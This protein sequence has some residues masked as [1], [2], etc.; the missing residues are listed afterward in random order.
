MKNSILL[1]L[2][3]LITGCG[4]S[5]PNSPE[6]QIRSVLTSIEEGV[7]NRSLSQVT[8]LIDDDYRDHKGQTKK[9]IKRYI[10]LQILRNQNIS[11]L[12]RVSSI[13]IEGTSASVELSVATAARGVDLNIEKNRLKADSHK[14]SIVLI[15]TNGEWKVTSS[16][17]KR[18]W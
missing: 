3:I 2:T 4:S 1:L 11:I 14:A 8:A 13:E 12:T 16:S 18:G 7:E 5:E 6:Q 17:W 10:Q 15:E 9:E